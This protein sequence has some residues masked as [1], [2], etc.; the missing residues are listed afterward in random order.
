[1]IVRAVHIRHYRSISAADLAPCEKL[2]VLIGKN[3]AGKSNML[4]AISLVLT[5]LQRG[6]IA[7]PWNVS[8]PQSEFHQRETGE[9]VRIGMEFSLST[10]VNQGLRDRLTKEAPH[11][12]RSIEQI[13]LHSSAVF[14]VAGALDGSRPFL[15]VEQI[16]VGSLCPK[17]EEL[18]VEGIKLLSVTRPVALEIF[19][20]VTS[21]ESLSLDIDAVT[22]LRE[23]RNP[24]P[25]IEYLL[26][27]PKERRASFLR[28]Y[29][30]YTER[31]RPDLARRIEA[32]LSPVTTQ[33][34]AKSALSRLTD[35]TR[36]E[37]ESYEKRETKGAISA[38][39][40]ETRVPPAYACWLM[41]ELGSTPVM[42]IREVKRPIGREEAETLLSLKVRRGGPERLTAVQQTVQGL[43]GVSVDAFQ[44]E[45]R[46]ERAAEMDV[47]DF[48][49]EAN[50][51]GIRE[52]LR[53]ILDLEL[54]SP[55]LVLIEE[56]EV[57]LHPGLA[58]VVANYLKEK[59][60]ST[61]M[62]VTTH[63]TDFVDFIPFQAVFLIS[64][65]E[66]NGT[67]C[68]TIQ[69][70]DAALKIPAEIGL[71]LSTVFMFDRLVFVEGPT[72]E[73]VFRE[74]ARK[75]ELDLTKSNVGFVYMQGT[76]NFAHFAAD[77]TLDF[78]S[79]RQIRI[80]FVVDRDEKDDEEVQRM[81]ERLGDRA[82]LKVLERREIENYL[83]NP[84]AVVR[85]IGEK[86]K[87]AGS[88]ASR[89][90][91]GQVQE[92]IETEATALKDEVVRL[93]IENRVLKPI[94]LQTRMT[95]GTALERLSGA[96]SQ[97]TEREQRFEEDSRAIRDDVEANW[98]TRA[99][100]LA[101]G[102]RVLERVAARFGATFSKERGDSERLARLVPDTVIP[103]EISELLRSITST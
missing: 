25:P 57:H 30:R 42:H 51:A 32:S 45:A 10:L 39:A 9:L 28:D 68:Q 40:G 73:A 86:L 12:D 18:A 82:T 13:G 75:M 17:G 4:S 54:K 91:A 58:R 80:H 2:N 65:D 81:M 6:K 35:E 14:I 69:A 59:S 52:A 89:P 87:L 16:A 15:F 90:T 64:R 67:V 55:R 37:M 50:G 24:G 7:G 88:N 72:D 41:Q 79:R 102:T 47:D 95:K 94:Y 8:R 77:A 23:G 92:A 62:F 78:L 29:L 5:H 63:S 3:N 31:N 96:I 34:E 21:A 38:F 46:G 101:P 44:S 27:Q 33:E 56:P 70:G 83:L 100:A 20:N 26:Q 49:V 103:S 99:A 43:L 11:L 53:L 84:E 61:Q 85:Y 98:P 74:F 71:R 66:H 36:E 93:R 76:R 60:Q 97:L 22:E 19:Q 48:L 1:M